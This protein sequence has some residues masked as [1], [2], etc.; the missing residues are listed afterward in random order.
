MPFATLRR[1]GRLG[2]KGV[3]ALDG[4]SLQNASTN[5]AVFQLAG[6]NYGLDIHA[7]WNSG[8]VYLLRRA[9]DGA[10]F[11]NVTSMTVDGYTSVYLPPGYYYFAV[12][13]ATG[14][15]ATLTRIPEGDG[16]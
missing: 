6:G 13:S 4:Y 11:C 14:V 2:A 15:W 5:S 8:S 7:S 12:T 16:L 3:R 9:G 10:S 1:I